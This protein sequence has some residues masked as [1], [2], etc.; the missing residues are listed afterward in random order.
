MAVR[1]K[2][3]KAV[4]LAKCLT[5]KSVEKI[6]EE[7]QQAITDRDSQL[8]TLEFKNEEHQ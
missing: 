6:Q 7:H 3:T 8:Q 1:Y 2:K 5:K 4:V